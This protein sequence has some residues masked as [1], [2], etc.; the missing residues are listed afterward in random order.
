MK[1]CLVGE[2]V[3]CPRVPVL[4]SFIFLKIIFLSLNKSGKNT[5]V[6]NSV[7]HNCANFQFEIHYIMGYTKNNKIW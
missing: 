4:F 6:A 2:S 7:S 3:I 5:G 1:V